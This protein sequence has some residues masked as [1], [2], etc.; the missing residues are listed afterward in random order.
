MRTNS[1]DHN[2]KGTRSEITGSKASSLLPPLVGTRF[3]GLFHPPPGVLFT[4]P[5]RYSFTIG[6]RL[7]FR[8]GRWSCQLQSGFLVSRF[9]QVRIPGRTH[10]FVYGAITL[11]GL[12]FQPASTPHAQTPGRSAALPGPALQ[13]RMRNGCRLPRIRFGL[14]PFRSPLLRESL[15][16]PF[17]RGTEMF[18]FPRLASTGLYIHPAM[19]GHHPGRVPP[20]GHPGINARVQLPLA[21]RSLPRPSSPVCA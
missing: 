17:P 14:I 19:T 2:A 10:G 16:F 6:H 8:L 21:Y 7:V 5:S 12:A 20:F 15:L 18:Q 9:T 13:P 1:P 3:Q 11:Y 4:F